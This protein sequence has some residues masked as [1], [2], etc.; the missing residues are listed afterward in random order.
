MKQ[1]ITSHT[2]LVVWQKAMDVVS[3]IYKV[4][5]NFPKDEQFG[6][7]SQMRRCAISIP[8]NIAEG[9]V[10]NT[11]KDFVH[12]LHIALGSCAELATQLDIAQR[13]NFVSES[14]YTEIVELLDEVGKMLS[15]LIASLNA[16]R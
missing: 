9:R 7:T 15:A 6:L 4:T 14:R 2:Q 8:S 1:K 3:D 12:F 16:K 11:T 10:R 5:K 13:Q